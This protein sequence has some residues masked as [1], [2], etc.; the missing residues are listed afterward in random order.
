MTGTDRDMDGTGPDY[1]EASLDPTDWAALKSLG[2]RM[3]DEAFDAIAGLEAA[4][5]WRSMPDSVRAAW[6]APLPHG[7]STPDEVYADYARLIAPYDSGNRHPRF[8]GWAQGAARR[9]A[10]W[11]SCWPGR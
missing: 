2:H 8:F 6:E 1:R 9:S 10:H 4:P 5:V 11:P 3:L 7:P